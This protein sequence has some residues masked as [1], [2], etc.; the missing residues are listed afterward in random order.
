MVSLD[1]AETQDIQ[2]HYVLTKHKVDLGSDSKNSLVNGNMHMAQD[3]PALHPRTPAI[4]M[5]TSEHSEMYIRHSMSSN[6]QT[7]T[8]LWWN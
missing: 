4:Y 1:K 5:Q 3:C 6:T 8:S 2:F 7:V